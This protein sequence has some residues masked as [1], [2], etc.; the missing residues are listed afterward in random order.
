[1]KKEPIKKIN[2]LLQNAWI[3]ADLT[4]EQCSKIKKILNEPRQF[5]FEEK[6]E[7]MLIY[8]SY[9]RES[10]MDFLKLSGNKF[11]RSGQIMNSLHKAGVSNLEDINKAIITG[12]LIIK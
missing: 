5:T 9:S 8:T 3:R 7:R 2:K 6:V 11:D 12:L 10:I 4:A 1:M